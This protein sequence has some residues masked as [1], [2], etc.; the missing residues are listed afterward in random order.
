MSQ[1]RYP[2]CLTTA[3]RVWFCRMLVNR[4]WDKPA[5][6]LLIG[7]I[8][9]CLIFNR[10]IDHHYWVQRAIYGTNSSI[11]DNTLIRVLFDIDFTCWIVALPLALCRTA[12]KLPFLWA[13][14]PSL[15]DLWL[16]VNRWFVH[17]EIHSYRALI[18]PAF[19]IHRLL[20]ILVPPSIG[21]AIRKSVR[22]HAHQSVPTQALP[23]SFQ[24]GV[25]PPAPRD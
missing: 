18:E 3:S 9:V 21:C 14:V 20:I 11:P 24:P 1:L 17:D 4:N 6:R 19:V 7:G 5:W 22:R 16:H 15:C 13:V 25:W 12:I 2:A 10:L 23:N 8:A